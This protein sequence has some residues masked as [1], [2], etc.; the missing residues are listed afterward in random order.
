MNLNFYRENSQGNAFIGQECRRNHQFDVKQ[1]FLQ[2]FKLYTLS[3]VCST[4][5]I[6]ID[7][8][9]NTKKSRIFVIIYKVLE[10]LKCRKGNEHTIRP[11]YVSSGNDPICSSA[12]R[13]AVKTLRKEQHATASEMKPF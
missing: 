11:T 2:N 9:E 8:N 1:I 6:M 13:T 3:W 4:S 12:N 7:R 5:T 10:V